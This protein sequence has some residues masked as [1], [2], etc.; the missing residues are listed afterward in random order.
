[1]GKGILVPVFLF[2]IGKQNLDIPLFP[3]S[4]SIRSIVA[5]ERERERERQSRKSPR[6]RLGSVIDDINILEHAPATIYHRLYT[7][8][9]Q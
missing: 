2:S 7:P 3:P 4:R 8:L 1:M 5:I 6:E 9:K